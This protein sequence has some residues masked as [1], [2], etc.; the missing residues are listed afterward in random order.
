[1]SGS[2]D[3]LRIRRSTADDEPAILALLGDS[4]GWGS[5]ERFASFFEWKHEKNP[6]GASPGW[7]A[8]DGDRIVGFRTFMRWEFEGPNGAVRAVRAVDTATHPDYQRRGIFARLTRR[9]LDELTAEGVHLV[10]NTPNQR[11]GPG[12]LKLGWLSVGRLA[13]AARPTSP[14]TLVRMARARQPAQRWSLPIDHGLAPA[15]VMSHPGVTDLLG[16]QPLVTGLRTC[17]TRRFLAWRYGFDPLG[18]RVVLAGRDIDDGFAIFRVRRRG[19]AAEASVSETIVADDAPKLR[20]SA[21]RRVVAT[22]G[23]D[24]VVTLDGPHPR[25]CGFF[26]V[27]GQGPNLV[28]RPLA[29]ETVLPLGGWNLSLGDVELF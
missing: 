1:M 18:Y 7:V 13:V 12:Y 20:R 5:D 25:R 8:V 10:F 29:G 21:L 22:P 26:P 24:Y 16:S 28:A 2:D 14:S 3:G 6:F 17:R 4:L 9:A 11:S 15:E 27:P 19:G 23:V